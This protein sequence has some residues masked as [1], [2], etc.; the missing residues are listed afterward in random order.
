[1]AGKLARRTKNLIRKTSGMYGRLP[2]IVNK[3]KGLQDANGNY[4]GKDIIGYITVNANA[5]TPFSRSKV[6]KGFFCCD[7]IDIEDGDLIFDRGDSRYYF[8]MDSKSQIY[9][10]ETVY[11][12][13]TMYRCDSIV[14]IQRFTEGVRDTFGRSISVAPE[15]VATNVYAMFNPQNFDVV[16]QQDRVI[17]QD[18]IKV[19]LQ[20]TVDV[21]V[22]DRIVVGAHKYHVISI[23]NVSLSKLI[24]CNV[25]TDVR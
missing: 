5:T 25:D 20:N 10:G 4:L 14:E 6:H 2:R 9:N 8:V 19:C 7:A 11:I 23:D 16:E 21:K 1:M 22:A 3:D 13:G 17:A 18:K 15:T 24:M 12:D